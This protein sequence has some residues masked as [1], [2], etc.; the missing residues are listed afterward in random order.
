MPFLVHISWPLVFHPWYYTHFGFDL[1]LKLEYTS[2]GISHGLILHPHSLDFQSLIQTSDVSLNWTGSVLRFFGTSCLSEF[3]P[4]WEHPP[5]VTNRLQFSLNIVLILTRCS[6]FT[7]A[8]CHPLGSGAALP[9]MQVD[10]LWTGST[11]SWCVYFLYLILLDEMKTKCIGFFER[12]GRG[13]IEGGGRRRG[14]GGEWGKKTKVVTCRKG[15]PPRSRTWSC[16][17]HVSTPWVLAT[18]WGSWSSPMG[19]PL[20][21]S[22]LLSPSRALKSFSTTISRR[23]IKQTKSSIVKNTNTGQVH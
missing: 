2:L 10:P 4:V 23:P 11:S 18:K 13:G 9:G 16:M 7:F 19:K 15:L 3:F 20:T 5:T 14:G 12:G 8:L 22:D 17:W 6:T 21:S 1:G